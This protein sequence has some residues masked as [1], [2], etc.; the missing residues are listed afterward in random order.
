MA[1][2]RTK[3]TMATPPS[4]TL[5]IIASG[6]RVVGDV[7]C[8]GVLR[9]DGTLEGSILGARQLLVSPGARVSGRVEADEIVVGGTIDGDVR[10]SHRLE[11]KGSAVVNGN[12]ETRS[13]VVPEGG[14]VNG[15]IRMIGG[16]ERSEPL[17][18]AAPS[19]KVE[20][21]PPVIAAA[22]TP[23]VVE[24]A[25]AKPREV[26]EETASEF[27]LAIAPEIASEAEVPAIEE[28]REE[29]APMVDVERV[30]VPTPRQ[31]SKRE[32]RKQ[33]RGGR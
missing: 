31:L 1:I 24:V 7:T 9:I 25:D 11:L 33:A 15:D 13:F 32:R 10:A 20:D 30:V 8:N 21:M 18:L 12:I 26:A 27:A 2:F 23:P 22:A 19:P 4:S 6:M 5:S 17:R 28:L 14:K 29:S 16:V 3:N